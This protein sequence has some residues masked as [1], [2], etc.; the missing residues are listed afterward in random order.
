MTEFEKW[1][2]QYCKEENLYAVEHIE[3]AKSTWKAALI[4]ALSQYSVG[5]YTSNNI[6]TDFIKKELKELK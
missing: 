1:Y 4:W 5:D 2:K 3:I 6:P